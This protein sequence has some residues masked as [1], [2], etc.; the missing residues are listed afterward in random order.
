MRRIFLYFAVAV[1]LSLHSLAVLWALAL[2]AAAAPFGAMLPPTE[3]GDGVRT[4]VLMHHKRL[5]ELEATLRRLAAAARASSASARPLIVH[6]AQSLR[7]SEA[8]AANAT[9][10]LLKS[11]AP[12]LAPAVEVWHAP[13]ILPVESDAVDGSYSVDARK[14]G[15]KKNSFRNMVRGLDAAFGGVAGAGASGSGGVPPSHA[16][17]MEDDIEVSLDLLAYSDMAASLVDATRTPP[18]CDWPRHLLLYTQVK[19]S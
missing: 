18:P 13:A 2:D 12:Q 19:A 17:V 10:G 15:T 1:V 14:F 3:L 16:I 9:G 6:V 4:V 8:A 5:P 11:L 7:P